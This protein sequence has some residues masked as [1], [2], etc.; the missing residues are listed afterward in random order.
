MLPTP[1]RYMATWIR[2]G[3]EWIRP[4]LNECFLLHPEHHMATWIRVGNE[5]SRPPLKVC[6]LLHPEQSYGHMNARLQHESEHS[7]AHPW[8]CISHSL[9]LECSMNLSA[10][11]CEWAPC[12]NQRMNQI[13]CLCERVL[14]NCRHSA[15]A[16]IRAQL[17]KCVSPARAH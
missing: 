7:C 5:W 6:F 16:W 9:M 8:I 3:N 10:C 1:E 4:P 13:A 11:L 14:S 15:A 2:V 12:T 17:C